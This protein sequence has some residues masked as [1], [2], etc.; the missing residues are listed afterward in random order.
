MC[1]Q[2]RATGNRVC[3]RK[4]GRWTLLLAAEQFSLTTTQ[5]GS[6]F[7]RKQQSGLFLGALK[8]FA[9]RWQH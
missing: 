3:C 2:A 9:G 5:P 8:T 6:M 7:R 1:P 4:D